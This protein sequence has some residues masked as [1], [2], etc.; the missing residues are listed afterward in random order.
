MPIDLD[1]RAYAIRPVRIIAD[2]FRYYE[3]VTFPGRAWS[4]C[5]MWLRRLRATGGLADDGSH[6]VLDILDTNDDVI[7]DFP[8]TRKGFEYLRHSLK[9][10]RVE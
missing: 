9:F 6:I 10:R 7:Q 2:K 8:I 5:E 3:A 1:P 4:G